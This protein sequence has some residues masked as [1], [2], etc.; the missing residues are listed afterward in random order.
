MPQGDN[1]DLQKEEDA[2]IIAAT[3]YNLLFIS[4]K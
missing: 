2:K 1:A 4:I 3:P